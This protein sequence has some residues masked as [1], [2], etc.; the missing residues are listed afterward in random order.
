MALEHWELELLQKEKDQQLWAEYVKKY[1]Q[2]YNCGCF[3]TDEGF[4]PGF[5]MCEISMQNGEYYSLEGWTHCE[6]Y[7]GPMVFPEPQYQR[8]DEE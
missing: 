2:C 6:H 5:G 3:F 4:K 1:A 7:D 8:E